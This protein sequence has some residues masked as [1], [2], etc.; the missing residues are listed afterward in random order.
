MNGFWKTVR[1]KLNITQR[2]STAYH[3]EIDGQPERAN[4]EVE[5]YLRKFVTYD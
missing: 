5:R 2:L 3:P 1:D 4:Q